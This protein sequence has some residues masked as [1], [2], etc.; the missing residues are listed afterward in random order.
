MQ[1][2][3]I[4]HAE[5][6][7]LLLFLIIQMLT[8]SALVTCIKFTTSILDNTIF[9]LKYF[10]FLFHIIAIISGHLFTFS[11]FYC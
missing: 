6:E 1:K 2:L 10:L 11:M 8:L 9:P 5:M 7:L 3:W 4:L